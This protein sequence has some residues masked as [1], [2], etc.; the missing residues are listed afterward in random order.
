MSEER[1]E[2]LLDELED[3][4][5]FPRT[6]SVPE[7]PA[8]S[9]R[10]ALLVLCRHFLFA[11]CFLCTSSK[12]RKKRK[13]SQRQSLGSDSGTAGSRKKGTRPSFDE[14]EVEEV[15]RGPL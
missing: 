13:H 11:D 9:G 3:K 6:G 2:A 7:P 14:E 5:L 8:P 10:C 12:M 4:A 15:N 1:A